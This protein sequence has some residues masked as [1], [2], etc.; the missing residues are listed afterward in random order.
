MTTNQSHQHQG[1]ILWTEAK[2]AT[3]R[4]MLTQAKAQSQPSIEFEG[5]T[6]LL[7]YG[8]YLL[9]YLENEIAMQKQSH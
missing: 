5:K 3:L 2:V 8:A 6:I 4:T 1:H 9:D 7:P